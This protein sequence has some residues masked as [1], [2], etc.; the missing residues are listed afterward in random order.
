MPA[1]VVQQRGLDGKGSAEQVV[2]EREV[3]PRLEQAELK[4]HTAE[5]DE[6]E[7]EPADRRG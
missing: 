3:H 4:K 2:A 6:I 7:L 1:E 5:A